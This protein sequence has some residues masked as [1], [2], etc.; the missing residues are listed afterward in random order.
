[1][2]DCLTEEQ[3][4]EA[5]QTGHWTDELRDH[6]ASCSPCAETALV[7]AALC[8]DARE[9]ETDDS[10][11]PDPRLIWLRARIESRRVKSTRATLAIVWVQRAA[12]ACAAV[13][14]LVAAPGLWRL[15]ARVKGALLPAATRF[16]LPVFVAA[17]GLVLAATFA[18]L[19]LMAL[20]NELVEGSRG[21]EA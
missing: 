11:L 15:L 16:D 13:I 6:C 20:W 19:A 18:V 17:P 8:A 12:I 10:P 9:L 1:M 5:A 21:D 2:N 7:T 3:V 14:G 4:R